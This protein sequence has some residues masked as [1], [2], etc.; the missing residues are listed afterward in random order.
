MDQTF[1]HG[2]FFSASLDSF[3]MFCRREPSSPADDGQYPKQSNWPL[4]QSDPQLILSIFTRKDCVYMSIWSNVKSARWL[5]LT[6]PPSCVSHTKTHIY[7]GIP[8]ENNRAH[9]TKNCMH[10]SPSPHDSSG[11]NV[12]SAAFWMRRLFFSVFHS[13]LNETISLC[14]K[15]IA[16]NWHQWLVYFYTACCP[17]SMNMTG[18]LLGVIEANTSYCKNLLCCLRCK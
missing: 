16:D 17:S 7:A 14:S 3:C 13:H 10:A 11:C 18:M 12:I 6:D 1:K 4:N 9:C 5:R 2:L 8:F 15:L